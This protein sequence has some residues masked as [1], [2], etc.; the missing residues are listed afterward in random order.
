MLSKIDGMIDENASNWNLKVTPGQVLTGSV[1][2]Q[3]VSNKSAKFKLSFEQAFTNDNVVVGYVSGNN[4]SSLRADMNLKK[5]TKVAKSEVTVPANS[6]TTVPVT[7]T[8]PNDS[9]DGSILGAVVVTK[10]IPAGA[11]T[12]ASFVNQFTYVKGVRLTETDNPVALD[13]TNTK[14]GRVAFV[15][16][17]QVFKLPI[18]NNTTAVMGNVAINTKITKVSNKEVVMTDKQTARQIAPNSTFTYN[19]TAQQVLS[20]GKYQ[21]VVKVTDK[22]TGKVWTFKNYFTITAAQEGRVRAVQ[23]LAFI[24]LWVWFLIGFLIL[25]LLFL[26][27]LLWKRRKKDKEEEQPT[28]VKMTGSDPAHPWRD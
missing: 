20:A 27:F 18:N 28:G 23:S 1:S 2:I 11:S 26:F 3:N 14:R 4:N 12:K 17:E 6:T 15:S 5:M 25:L 13:L 10:A 19:L 7:I 16:N 9:F 21:Y 8:M 24:P 22:V